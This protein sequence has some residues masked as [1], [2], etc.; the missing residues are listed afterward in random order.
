MRLYVV[1]SLMPHTQ[2]GSYRD[3][4]TS[5]VNLS[6]PFSFVSLVPLV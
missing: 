5:D 1:L 4:I 6:F 3:L 2:A